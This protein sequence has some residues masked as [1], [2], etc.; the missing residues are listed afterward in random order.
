[1]TDYSII[2]PPGAPAAGG[3][4]E[5]K[6]DVGNTSL[7]SIDTKATTTNTHLST[8]AAE[9]FSTETTLSALNA[10]VTAVNTGAVVISTFPDNEPF[11]LAQ[12]GGS[13]TTLGQKAMTASVPIV[14]ASDQSTIQVDITDEAARDLGKV[15]VASLDQYTPVAGRLPVDGSGVTQPISGTVATKTALTAASPTSASV[16]VVSA[17]ALAANAT[18]KGLVLVNTSANNIS[19]G[20]GATAVLNS[21]VTLLSNG[22]TFNMDEYDFN[23]SAVNAIAGGAASNLA[24]QE[25]TT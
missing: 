8:I 17:Q 5:A 7:A 2:S 24:I 22:G 9:D 14:L 4:T 25:Y 12:W 1:M 3:A 16:G 21:G 23:T 10:K 6:Q 15:D 19:L 18:R 13:A 11:N 20:F